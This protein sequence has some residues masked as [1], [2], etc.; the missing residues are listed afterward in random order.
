MKLRNLLLSTFIIITIIGH[1][2][3]KLIISD[4]IRLP[5]DSIESL[6]LISDLNNFIISTQKDN[7]TNKYVLP[8]E[9]VETFILIDEFKKI[10]NSNGDETFFKPYLNNITAIENGKYLIQ[11]SHIGIRDNTPHLRSV[12]N[13]IAHKNND[14]F[15]FSSPLIN[16]TT[17]WKTI[18]IENFT[19]NYKNKINHENITNYVNLSKEFDKKLN[20]K[21]K[22]TKF[23]FAKNR[24][25]LL[26]LIGVDYK[27]DYNGYPLGVF[28][29]IN[30]NEKLVV[31]G[32]KNEHFEN[33]DP[34]DLWHDRLSLVIS[35]RKVNKPVDEACAYLYGGSWGISWQDIFTRFIEKV[36]IDKNADWKY[37]K[38]NN[39]NFGENKS[40]RLMVDYVITALIVQKIEKE[41][42]FAG[43]WELLNS[44][45]YEKGNENYYTTLEKVIGIS[46][47]NY[48]QE[49]WKL[50]KNEQIKNFK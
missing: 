41:K 9:S 32:N 35:R 33:F 27:I 19:F 40:K 12:F 14:T 44:G 22:K 10:E 23:Y 28:S 13:L 8:K 50:I 5:K 3:S 47:E 15:L 6:Q 49:V 16:N 31:F 18:T 29:A 45:K 21:G 34:H 46:K 30:G 7:K 37:F 39:A 42:G 4:Q 26:K 1:A 17:N 20:S 43:V 11:I 25:E 38:E 24:T 2:Q 36:A 48:N